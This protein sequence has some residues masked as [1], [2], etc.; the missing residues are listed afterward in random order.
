MGPPPKTTSFL[1]RRNSRAIRHS[2][3]VL[4]E[5]GDALFDVLH[6]NNLPIGGYRESFVYYIA[7]NRW[8]LVVMMNNAACLFS[9]VQF[10]KP[11]CDLTSPKIHELRMFVERYS[12]LLIDWH[13]IAGK[14]IHLVNTDPP[15]NVKVE[16]RSKNVIAAGLSSFT[17]DAAS[18]KLKNDQ[19]M[20]AF[21]HAINK[22]QS[23]G[24]RVGNGD[25]G[26]SS[27]KDASQGPTTGE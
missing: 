19:G 6:D 22:E 15:Y 17:N 13:Q 26:R 4:S 18:S 3:F 7:G 10:G 11:A 16:P 25:G 5:P 1:G 14:P 24:R 12:V 23:Q 20:A 21:T 2:L 27:P 9:A 8:R